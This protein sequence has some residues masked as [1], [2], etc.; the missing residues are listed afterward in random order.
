[1]L[2][3]C[4]QIWSLGPLIP[5]PPLCA[6]PSIHTSASTQTKPKLPQAII[7]EYALKLHVDLSATLAPVVEIIASLRNIS[8]Q[9]MPAV[10]G[11]GAVSGRGARGMRWEGSGRWA[12]TGRDCKWASSLGLSRAEA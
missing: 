5:R 8:M 7:K 3:A 2:P 11:V 12:G 10:S 4:P 1:M 9:G 6:S